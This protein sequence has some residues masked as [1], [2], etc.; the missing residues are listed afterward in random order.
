M[1]NNQPDP[2]LSKRQFLISLSTLSAGTLLNSCAGIDQLGGLGNLS[3]GPGLSPSFLI[4]PQTMMSKLA[5]HFPYKRNYQGLVNLNFS[6]P[7]VS[8]VPDSEKVRVGLTT[9]GGLAGTGSQLGG[10]CQLACGLRYD[11]KNR[12]VYLKDST[13]ENFT[14]NGVST[15]LTSGIKDVANLVGKDLLERYPVYTLDNTPGLGLLKKMNV[16][17]EGVLLSFGLL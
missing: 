10:R 8:M 7:V 13:V 12:G 17:N 5:P 11:P 3:F 16:T 14:L 9:L 15:Q 2:T 4:K 6:D 1:E